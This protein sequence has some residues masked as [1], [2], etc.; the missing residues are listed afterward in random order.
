MNKKVA[1]FHNLLV[2]LHA[3]SGNFGI[4]T[5]EQNYKSSTSTW[6]GAE[7]YFFLVISCDKSWNF[8]I[9]A[10]NFELLLCL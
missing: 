8:M 7:Y 3:K 4:Q 10:I 9:S 2:L 5:A 6:L 1:N